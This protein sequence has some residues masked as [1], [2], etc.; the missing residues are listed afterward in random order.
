VGLKRNYFSG[1]MVLPKNLR[2]IKTRASG[3]GFNWALPIKLFS[4]S[5][6]KDWATI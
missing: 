6:V 5:G 2:L 1:H 4:A 3:T